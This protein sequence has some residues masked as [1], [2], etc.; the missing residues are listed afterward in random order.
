[1]FRREAQAGGPGVARLLALY[2]RLGVRSRMIAGFVEMAEEFGELVL[3][4]VGKFK[5]PTQ[6]P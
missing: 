2:S 4:V 1:M 5:T 3:P 6:D